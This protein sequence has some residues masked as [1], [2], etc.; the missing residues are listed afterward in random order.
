ML[1]DLKPILHLLPLIILTTAYIT[2]IRQYKKDGERVPR[3][4]IAQLAV[5]MYGMAIWVCFLIERVRRIIIRS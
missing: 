1:E 4:G 2:G 5:M 3:G